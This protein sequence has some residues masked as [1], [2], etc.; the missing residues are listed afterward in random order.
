MGAELKQGSPVN[1]SEDPVARSAELRAIVAVAEEL[2]FTRAAERLHLSQQTVSETVRGLERELGVELLERTT[3]EVHLTAAGRTLLEQGR[4]TLIAADA[5]FAAARA[6]GAGEAGSLRVGVTPAIGLDDREDVVRAL[7]AQSPEL[8]VAL[9]E[10]RPGELRRSLRDREVDVALN[11]VSGSDDESI[12]T[13]PLRPSR[14]DVYAPAG[15][16][17]AGRGGLTLAD[18]DG[19]RLLMPSPPGTPYTDLLVAVFA[20]AGATVTP[21]EA[22]LTG[23]GAHLSELEQTAAV[24]VLGLGAPT[25]AGVVA[26]GVEDFTLPLQLLWPAGRPPVWVDRIRRALGPHPVAAQGAGVSER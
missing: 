5:A 16:R 10:L 2:S 25:P 4:Q 13:A 21:V 20:A 17:L 23:A 18:F 15:H 1:S 12:E 6:V 24:T 26:L 9:L 14:M 22:K 7:R 11:R 3:R 19:E 8:S